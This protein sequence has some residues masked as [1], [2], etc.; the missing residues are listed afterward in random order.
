MLKLRFTATL[1]CKPSRARFAATDTVGRKHGTKHVR[2]P[3]L[4]YFQRD[5]RKTIRL[6]RCLQ[7]QPENHLPYDTRMDTRKSEINVRLQYLQSS[8]VY[9]F[10]FHGSGLVGCCTKVSIVHLGCVHCVF[11]RK[12][13][14]S[15]QSSSINSL[16][17]SLILI[18]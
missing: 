2:L 8:L 14:S 6:E 11:F 5:N 10:I 12:T 1:A 7:H 4:A 17:K 15:L 3:L 16:V 9:Y 13:R 18:S